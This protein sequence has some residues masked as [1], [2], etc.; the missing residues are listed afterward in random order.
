MMR[1]TS[2]YK[3]V[4]RLVYILKGTL[5]RYNNWVNDLPDMWIENN[6]HTNQSSPKLNKL[7]NLL[8]Y[9]CPR[10]PFLSLEAWPKVA[11]VEIIWYY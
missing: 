8:Y 7:K 5:T 6:N 4:V 9:K 3:Q 11:V 2:S 1:F 10:E